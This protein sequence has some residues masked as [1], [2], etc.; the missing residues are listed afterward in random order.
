MVFFEILCGITAVLLAVY[1]YFTSTFNFWKSRGIRGP[2]PIP[3]F[4]NIKDVMLMKKS[5]TDYLVEIYNNYKDE[6]MVGTFTIRTPALVVKDPDL[7]KDIL[8][9]DFTK[10]ADRGFPLQEKLEPLS[11]HLAGL[12]FKRWRPLRTRLSP[13]FTSVKLKGMFSLMSQCADQLE[14][15]LEKLASK[16][17]PIECR[18]LTAKYAT[19]VIGTCAFGIEMNALSEED[20]EFRKIGRLIFTPTWGNN[21]R[22]RCV[23][24]LPQILCNLLSYV[25][26]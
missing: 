21:L 8:I 16:N 15:Y 24:F 3:G 14:Q 13:T 20:S 1:Y 18:E 17:E 11:Q 10:F 26:L 19:D 6:S 23:Q 7:I 25:Y 22:Y 9:K 4:G 5:V 12:E 2:Q